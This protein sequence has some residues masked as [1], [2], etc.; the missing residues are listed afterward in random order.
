MQQNRAIRVVKSG[1]KIADDRHPEKPAALAERE[2]R[3]VVSGWIAEHARAAEEL[4]V[5][6]AAL[7]ADPGSRFPRVA[8][9][10]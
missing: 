8:P 10:A 3:A 5:A 1:Q 7:L 6:S 9:R 2:M 4:R